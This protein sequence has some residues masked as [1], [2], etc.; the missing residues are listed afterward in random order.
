MRFTHVRLD[1]PAAFRFAIF[2]GLYDFTF[3]QEAEFVFSAD[4]LGVCDG[5]QML[6]FDLPGEQFFRSSVP[7]FQQSL[8]REREE[9]QQC[10]V[11]HY[12]SSGCRRPGC[13]VRPIFPDRPNPRVGSC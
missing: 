1:M 2:G 12:P 3:V 4:F 11:R 6:V 9:V 8:F 5:A 7:V 10:S 13:T